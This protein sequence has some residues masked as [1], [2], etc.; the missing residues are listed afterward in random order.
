MF[1]GGGGV[2]A[3]IGCRLRCSGFNCREAG[4]FIVSTEKTGCFE[5]AHSLFKI[6]FRSTRA[7]SDESVTASLVPDSENV[8]IFIFINWIIDCFGHIN[9]T[10]GSFFVVC[11]RQVQ[12]TKWQLPDSM[13]YC[14]SSIS[15]DVDTPETFNVLAEV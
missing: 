10:S 8:F 12:Q 14:L 2:Q 9:L 4:V 13:M 1:D 6:R 11:C 15:D 3:G 7:P 5:H